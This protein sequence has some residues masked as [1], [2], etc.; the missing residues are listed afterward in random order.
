MNTI[1]ALLRIALLVVCCIFG[2]MV[3]AAMANDEGN[4][5]ILF[6]VCCAL[7]GTAGWLFS[8]YEKEGA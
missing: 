6:V 8:I 3:A 5:A 7:F 1:N 4:K 2:L